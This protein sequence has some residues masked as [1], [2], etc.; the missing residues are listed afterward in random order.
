MSCY[1]WWL[2]LASPE[3]VWVWVLN[4]RGGRNY[5]YCR[6]KGRSKLL[7]R[8]L[9]FGWHMLPP[10]P[11]CIFR[12]QVWSIALSNLVSRHSS[13]CVTPEC[14]TSVSAF[15][16]MSHLGTTSPELRQSST[17]SVLNILMLQEMSKEGRQALAYWLLIESKV[18]SVINEQHYYANYLIEPK[19]VF[20]LFFRSI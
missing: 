4:M 13:S 18:Q 20:A 1:F 14:D 5:F 19:D 11:S 3:R 17:A 9:S 10:S 12:C 16:R 2:W 6:F 15:W 8:V 7:K